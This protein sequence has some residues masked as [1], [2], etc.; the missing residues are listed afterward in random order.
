MDQVAQLLGAV[1]ILAAFA[2]A[3]FR[4][5]QPQS[6]LYLVLN[7]VGS[8]ILAV[9]AAEGRQWGFLLLEVCWAVVSLWAIFDRARGRAAAEVRSDSGGPESGSC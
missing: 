3:Q 5:M 9:V 4:L 8:A 1:L 2:L 6:Y 7:F